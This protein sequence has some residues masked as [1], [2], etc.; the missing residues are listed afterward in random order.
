MKIMICPHAVPDCSTCE[1]SAMGLEIRDLRRVLAAARMLLNDPTSS[2]CLEH[3]RA[4]VEMATET[5]TTELRKTE[6]RIE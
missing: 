5:E 6:P 2:A 3:L 1:K 4:F